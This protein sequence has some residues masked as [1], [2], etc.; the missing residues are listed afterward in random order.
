MWCY[1][2]TV[3][4]VLFCS[5]L[6][7]PPLKS[8]TVLYFQHFPPRCIIFFTS[9]LTHQETYTH[10]SVYDQRIIWLIQ[11]FGIVILWLS[12]DLGLD[13]AVCMFMGKILKVFFVSGG[14]ISTCN[15]TY[16]IRV[17]RYLN[18][19][20]KCPKIY[21][22]SLLPEMSFRCVDCFH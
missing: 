15:G 6:L 14:I 2:L 10:S 11:L 8:L 21:L 5:W 13:L 22:C 1:Y 18:A 16:F 7:F 19:R 4:S 20:H 17:L 3:L 12:T 9:Y